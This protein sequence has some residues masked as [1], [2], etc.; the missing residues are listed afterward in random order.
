MPALR[1]E[2]VQLT[3]HQ[4][5]WQF[6][7]VALL[8]RLSKVVAI[9]D[10]LESF[11]YVLLYYA[12]RYLRSNCLDVGN[13]IEDFFDSYTLQAGEYKCGSTKSTTMR[14]FEKGMLALDSTAN[15][16]V[17][18]RFNSPMDDLLS[19]LLE[20]FQ[21]HYR[22]EAHEAMKRNAKKLQSSVNQ[23]P[24]PS[25]QSP[26]PQVPKRVHALYFHSTATQ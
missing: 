6:M 8:S 12:I 1:L 25:P 5:T 26:S 11:F 20:R 13:W 18:L 17:Q 15:L 21:A 23:L 2:T 22:V 16:P 7:S 24:L 4:G 10:E 9:P 3:C 14:S 19:T